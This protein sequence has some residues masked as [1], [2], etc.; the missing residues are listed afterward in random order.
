MKWVLIL[1]VM[2][3]HGKLM[4]EPTETDWHTCRMSER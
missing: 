3:S 1:V 4:H 2:T